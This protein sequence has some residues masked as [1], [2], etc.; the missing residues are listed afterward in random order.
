MDGKG[1]GLPWGCGWRAMGSTGV[2]QGITVAME[3]K[4]FQKTLSF[5]RIQ[6]R[7]WGIKEKEEAKTM[8]HLLGFWVGLSLNCPWGNLQQQLAFRP[9]SNTQGQSGR[10]R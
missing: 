2:C 7:G 5:K 10:D 9:W 6:S 4:R 8:S 1:Q 3:K